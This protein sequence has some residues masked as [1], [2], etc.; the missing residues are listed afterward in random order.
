M[1]WSLPFFITVMTFNSWR[2]HTLI[3]YFTKPPNC[4]VCYYF[5]KYENEG[6][7]TRTRVHWFLQVTQRSYI[8]ARLSPNLLDLFIDSC[9]FIS[10]EIWKTEHNTEMDCGKRELNHL[11]KTLNEDKIYICRKKL[12]LQ[13][14]PRCV[15]NVQVSPPARCKMY[16]PDGKPTSDS[17][18]AHLPC[19]P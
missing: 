14:N 10:T 1:K 6:Y 19:L 16:L 11:W 2:T 17:P 8:V 12:K 15:F 7:V 9:N 18:E 3:T 4:I 13:L 5:V